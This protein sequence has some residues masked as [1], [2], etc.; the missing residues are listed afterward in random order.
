MPK[1]ISGILSGQDF[2]FVTKACPFQWVK[3]KQT[4]LALQK[5]LNILTWSG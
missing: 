4:Q 5:L 3:S 2:K 1:E